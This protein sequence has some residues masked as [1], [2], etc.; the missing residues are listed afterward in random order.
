MVFRK[1]YFAKSS[2]TFGIVAGIYKPSSL[3]SLFP[4]PIGSV[5]DQFA[6]ALGD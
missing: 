3:M 5:C 2:G 4:E 1:L 6:A